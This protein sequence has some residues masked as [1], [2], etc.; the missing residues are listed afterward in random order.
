MAATAF[1]SVILGNLFGSETMRRVFLDQTRVAIYLDIEA[2]LARVEARLGIIP[3]AAA[4][5]I[6]VQ[7]KIEH[8]DLEKL[9]HRTEVV[10]SPVIP[11]VE[12]LVARCDGN[13]GQYVHWGAT[14]QDITDTATVIQVREALTL[15]ENELRVISV[16]LAKLARRYR[17]TPMA[18]RSMMQ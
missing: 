12:Q 18:G 1:D 10:C 2:A 14:T 6:S 7:A 3:A 5:E 8:I 13:L 16:S 11:V 4:D 9:R 17:D 15:V